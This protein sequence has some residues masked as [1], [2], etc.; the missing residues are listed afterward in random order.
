MAEAL[1]YDLLRQ[2]TPAFY[3]KRFRILTGT[4]FKFY[5]LIPLDF[6]YGYLLRRISSKW[7]NFTG[8]V[9]PP[10]DYELIHTTRGRK[11]N[12]IPAPLRLISTPGT[13]GVTVV[14]APSPVDNAGF[15]VCMSDEPLK[16]RVVI[17]EYYFYRETLYLNLYFRAVAG[18]EIDRYI[19]IMLDGYLI[20]EKDLE[21]W[22]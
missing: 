2:Q 3:Y 14:N 12:N 15:N 5:F 10:L 16:N 13:D 9:Q 21:M 7:A 11:L 8:E 18:V 4:A 17:N 6:G 22:G 20:P 1:N 19:D